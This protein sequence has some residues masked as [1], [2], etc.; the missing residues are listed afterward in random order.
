MK[1]DQITLKTL[2]ERKLMKDRVNTKNF[3]NMRSESIKVTKWFSQFT[4]M[5]AYIPAGIMKVFITGLYFIL[6]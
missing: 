4:Q 3:L 5:H 1:I 2:S 6:I